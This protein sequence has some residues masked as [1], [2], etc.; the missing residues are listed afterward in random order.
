[1]KHLIAAATHPRAHQWGL[2]PW[3]R[4]SLVLAVA[5]GV[6]L[7]IGCTYFLAEPT[8]ARHSALQIALNIASMRTWGVV[9]I[10]VGLAALLSSRWPPAS[11]FWGYTLMATLACW[12]ALCYFLGVALGAEN[13]STSGGLVWLLVASLWLA[14]AGLVDP[15][16]FKVC[17][18][19]EHL[20]HVPEESP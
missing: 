6:Y 12:W 13:Q 9:W 4:H 19:C 11:K 3:T 15:T 1:M 2:R 17:G 20:G 5:G 18:T 8:E 10:A 7:A 16:E 14:I